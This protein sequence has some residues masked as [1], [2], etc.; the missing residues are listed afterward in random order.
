MATRTKS[1]L[2]FLDSASRLLMRSCPAVSAHLQQGLTDEAFAT[3]TSLGDARKHE[4]CLACGSI[5]TPESSTTQLVKDET[6]P[7][8]QSGRPQR[9]TLVT[10]C[11]KCG[12][13]SRSNIPPA[14]APNRRKKPASDSAES[15][16]D[17]SQAKI[18]R[19][20]KQSLRKKGQSLHTMLRDQRVPARG[21]PASKFG[22]SLMDLMKSDTG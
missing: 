14:S 20:R 6:E 12:C 9:K 13:S 11:S 21:P 16:G 3:G 5:A 18:S 2:A 8:K 1:N 19:K 15:K 17:E 7:R 22:L 4:I 10:K